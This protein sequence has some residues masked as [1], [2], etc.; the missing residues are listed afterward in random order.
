MRY[1]T[2]LAEA[3]HY[4]SRHVPRWTSVVSGVVSGFSRTTTLALASVATLAIG[5]MT[6]MAQGSA[7]TSTRILNAAA[8]PQN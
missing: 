8:E 5:T 4:A 7:V 3:R 6:L 2:G 1:S